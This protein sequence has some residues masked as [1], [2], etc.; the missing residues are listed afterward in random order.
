M[1]SVTATGGSLEQARERA[2]EGVAAVRMRGGF[3]R[4]DIAARA[5]R[6]EIRVPTQEAT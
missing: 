1:L 3:W 2:Y 4:S 6:G 5:A